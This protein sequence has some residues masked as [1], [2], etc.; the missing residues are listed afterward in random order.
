MRTSLC[1]GW[2]KGFS[3]SLSV[4]LVSLGAVLGEGIPEPPLVIYGV[5]RNTNSDANVRWNFGTLR[6]TFQA[7]IGSP[8]TVS[9]SLT[10]IHDQ[11]SYVL[12]VPCESEVGGFS[13]SASALRLRSSPLAYNRSQVAVL[14]LDG[15]SYPASLVA[16][17]TTNW[18]LTS[19]NRGGLERVDLAVSIPLI[20][21]EGNGLLDEWERFY[22]RGT[23]HDPGADA[24]G[25]GLS[26]WAE[27]KAGTNPQDPDSRFK[28]I[29][30][31]PDARGG[32]YVEWSSTPDTWYV[33]QRSSS[34]LSGFT[35]ISTN[36][37]A[38]APVNGYWDASATGAGP[39]F[40][41]LRLERVFIASL[42]L[43][44]NS[45]PDDWERLYFGDYGMNPLADP[46]RDAMATSLEYRAG[47][48]P[49]DRNSVLRFVS[50]QRALQGPT[51]LRW[52][53]VWNKSYRILR[54]SNPQSG[55]TAVATGLNGSPP[56]N[57][58]QDI[59]AA[60]S[61]SRFY[62]VQVEE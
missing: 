47:T 3:A 51:T 44:A 55:Y 39:Y 56:V 1:Q 48:N 19:R 45:L 49:N 22:F 43:D 13:N 57:V 37:P 17:A 61:G 35:D 36:I 31:T 62:R 15:T 38:T 25:D 9:A 40:Y 26:N 42:D 2:R 46:D 24:D 18:V 16:P 6:W 5:V 12:Q 21:A 41:R 7:P 30:V 20:D 27:Y 8:V 11:F 10:N 33:V 60:G 53:S 14:T 50:I 54:S 29:R 59:S 58:Y 34:L 4:L 28:F 52:L 32:S 23:G